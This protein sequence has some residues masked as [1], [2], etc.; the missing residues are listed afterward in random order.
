MLRDLW[1]VL[2]G[3]GISLDVAEARALGAP[4]GDTIS[5]WAAMEARHGS[6]F[7]HLACLA[8]W[9]VQRH[10]CRDQLRNIPMAPVSYLKAGVL[11]VLFAPV[12]GI[13][14]LLRGIG[15]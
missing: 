6:A 14:R 15:G 3:A 7:A 1:A 12:A 10:H 13:I 11:L 4:S 5:L 2:K 8:L 9:I